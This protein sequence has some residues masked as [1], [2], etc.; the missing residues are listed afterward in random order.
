M[1][2]QILIWTLFSLKKKKKEKFI[3]WTQKTKDTFWAH[4]EQTKNISRDDLG[5]N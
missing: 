4:E 1:R 5:P 3:I 2:K